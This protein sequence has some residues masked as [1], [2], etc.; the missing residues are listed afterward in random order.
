ML[1]SVWDKLDGMK[2]TNGKSYPRELHRLEWEIV[3]TGQ[4]AIIRYV[5]MRR[6]ID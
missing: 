1:V 3:T 6:V 5:D 2:R 4:Q